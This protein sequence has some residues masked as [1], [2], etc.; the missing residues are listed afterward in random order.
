MRR[1]IYLFFI[2]CIA[3]ILKASPAPDQKTSFHITIL[4]STGE[5]QPG[6]ILKIKNRNM[7]Y[8]GNEQ[9]IIA[10]EHEVNPN[11]Y[12]TAELYFPF[13]QQTP[14][15]SFLLTTAVADTTLYIDN[16]EDI[17]A[18]KQS[19]QT[20]AIE[21]IVHTPKG[22]PFT[23]AIISIQGTGRSVLSDEIGLFH[24]EADYNHP[25]VIRAKGMENLSLDI[26]RF[27][28][29]GEEPLPITLTPKGANRIYRSVEQMP[30]FPGGMKAMRNYIKRYLKYPERS[31]KDSIEGVVGVQFIVEK[32]GE[33]TSPL[34]VRS[35][36]DE[37][38]EA[39][40]ELIRR[41]PRWIAGKDHGTPV[42]CK[43]SIPIQFKLPQKETAATSSTQTTGNNPAASRKENK[44]E[45]LPAALRAPLPVNLLPEQKVS[46]QTQVQPG[47]LEI[48]WP[49]AL[50]G[51]K[52]KRRR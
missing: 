39:A 51:K 35:L 6:I 17:A 32:N 38:D 29:Y 44:K 16:P 48:T 47:K 37:L 46:W 42:R 31:R 4:K 36:N 11:Y 40:L 25:I 3:A 18:L 14:L 7:E 13:D 28:Q 34:I 9:G 49:H 1:S 24:I 22:D 21:G 23:G 2:C 19:G 43:Y 5:P 45:I 41:M 20:F 8:S 15:S 50:K 33:I 27:Q 30:R 52:P 12:R 26:T 10:F